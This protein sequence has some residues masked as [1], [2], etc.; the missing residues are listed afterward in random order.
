[1]TAMDINF[2]RAGPG[3]GQVPLKAGVL[4]KSC[5]LASSELQLGSL[6]EMREEPVLAAL[7]SILANA[8][9]NGICSDV[10]IAF[11][12]KYPMLFLLIHVVRVRVRECELLKR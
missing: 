1:M 11:D 9:S 7:D 4:D 8:G 10:F 3:N 6:E 12:F 2:S 5:V